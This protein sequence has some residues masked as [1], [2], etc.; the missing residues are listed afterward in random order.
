VV[1]LRTRA[2]AGAAAGG[3][4]LRRPLAN[5]E[6][7]PLEVAGLGTFHGRW[8]GTL[9]DPV[10]AGRFSGDDVRY[11][12]VSWGHAEWAGSTS[13]AEVRSHSLVLR[14]DGAEL[15]LDGRLET[16]LPGERDGVDLSLRLRDWPSEDIA[17]ALGWELDLAG[18]VSGRARVEGR[19]SAPSGE[20]E[21]TSPSARFTRLPLADLELTARL[22]R[23]AT[24]VTKGRAVVAGGKVEFRGTLDAEG[25]WDASV[26]AADVELSELFP[27]LAPE[28]RWGGRVSGQALVQGVPGRPRLEGRLTSNRVFLGDE[29]IGA[30]EATLRGRGDGRIA[31]Q[32]T[33]RSARVDLALSGDVAASAPFQAQLDLRM[34]ETSLDPFLRV[35]QPRWPSAAGLVAS[36]Q[37][38][39]RGPLADPR[40]IEATAELPKLE[41]L[42]P[43]YPVTNREPVRARIANGAL[44]IEG[45]RLAG[46]D[47]DLEVAGTLALLDDD[48]PLA[49]ELRGAADLRALTFLSREL[50]GRGAAQVAMTVSGVRKAP[51]LDGTLAVT[52]GAV[53][54][55][56]FPHGVE[57]ITGTVRFTQA[58]ADLQ[59]VTGVVGGGPVTLSGHA[60]FAAGALSSFDLEASGRDM[61]LRY[62]EGLRSRVDADLRFFG[63][64]RQQWLAGDVEVKQAVWTK[65]YDVASELLSEGRSFE[66][67]ASLGGGLRY[68]IHVRA[69]GS[70]RVDNN[71]AALSARAD[72]RLTG[73][74]GA[75]VVLG[76]A[77]V[78][79]GRVYFQ[80]N[81]YVIRRGTIDFT[82]PRKTAPLFD[83]E[84]ET[85]IS[86]FRITLK[87]NGTLE[88]VYP[89]LTSDPPLDAVGIL[90]LLAG[91]D[92]NTVLSFDAA[93]R[94]AAQSQLAATGAATLAAGRLSEEVG[95]ERGAE[96]LLGLNRFSID[97]GLNRFS[98]DPTA[99]RANLS[100]TARLTV[101]KRLTPDVSVLYSV[102]LG[103][104]AERLVSVE[105]TLSD[106]FSLLMTRAPEP[107]GFGFDLRLRRSR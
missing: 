37:A 23:G 77:E 94:S 75:P 54:V 30:L 71:L 38:T 10:Y 107:A 95:L 106:R 89:T 103:G 74:F 98:V 33:C 69:P 28:T 1:Y 76:R 9:S 11:L 44:A 6:A 90:S 24:E 32:G 2:G 104:A 13:A 87:V 64:A 40:A 79:R 20:L 61:S 67:D 12:D 58:G 49:L 26:D 19:R 59:D 92:P 50:R 55:R 62:P 105:Y 46:E 51:V 84:A 8:T 31:V 81:T 27:E 45:L 82:N 16:G 66:E 29:G 22:D 91:A 102:D 41:F 78:D 18:P 73:S 68:D 35:V 70:L 72:L 3:G 39:V 65:R 96:K 83:L 86:S 7:A 5:A 88:R 21:V 53:R 80:G 47:T 99:S 60:A 48:G 17:K 14:K 85:R 52:G 36:G 56:G 57:D 25:V 101:G 63:D 4:R 100:T 42:L 93:A 34:H 43:D 97:P 15:W